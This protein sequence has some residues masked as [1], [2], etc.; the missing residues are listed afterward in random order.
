MLRGRG[1]SLDEVKRRPH[2]VVFEGLMPGR[3]YSDHLQTDDGRVDCCPPAFAD[4]LE[5]CAR[6]LEELEAEGPQ[7][8]KMISLRDPYMHN[9]WYAN[10]ARMKGGAKDR[11]YL[12]VHPEDARERSLATGDKV[13]LYNEWGEVEVEMRTD[14]DLMRGVVALTHGWGNARTPGMRVAQAT[15]GVNPNALLPSGP[16][17]FDPLSSQA[18]MT[19]V[20]VEVAPR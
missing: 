15:P 2:G 4:A 14:E 6:Q 20:P 11:N 18:F 13:R 17:S 10:L 19:G 8:L 9:S 12:Y 3:F 1:L 16:G 5:R 7:R